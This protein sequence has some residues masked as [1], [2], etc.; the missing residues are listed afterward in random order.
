MTDPVT[1]DARHTKNS[2]IICIVLTTA[3]SSIFYLP[4]IHRL[5][6]GLLILGLMWC[7]GRLPSVCARA[8]V[9]PALS[10]L[11]PTV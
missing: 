4:V 10:I 2:I 8:G 1:A 11:V 9:F 6:P 5:S 3:L 7:P